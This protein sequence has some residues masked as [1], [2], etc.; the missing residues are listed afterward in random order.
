MS[1]CKYDKDHEKDG[2]GFIYEENHLSGMV[3]FDKNKVSKTI[4]TFKGKEMTELNENGDTLYIGG[5][6]DSQKK[7][8]PRNGE[9]KE[10]H[11][12]SIVHILLISHHYH[13][14]S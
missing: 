7:Q 10:F 14:T 13:L 8:Y 11:E 6:I 1:V 12:G 3:E 2:I 5:Y 9:G 4:K